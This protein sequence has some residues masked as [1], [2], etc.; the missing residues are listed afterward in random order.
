MILRRVIEHVKTQNW[1]AV[2]IDFA[3]VVVG[4]YMGIE[5]ANWNDARRDR[6]AEAVY[7]DRLGREIS[8]IVP[9]VEASHESVRNRLHRMVEVRDFFKTGEGAAALGGE[10]C[11]ALGTSHIF[12]ATIFYPPTIKEMIATG[13]IILIRDNVIRTAIL[14]LDQTNAESSQLRTDIQ[15][16]RLPLAR[17]Y[18]DLIT[19][20][21]S[22]W[23]D[24]TCDVES[25]RRN[26]SFLNDFIDNMQ[27]SE[28]YASR[29]TGRQSKV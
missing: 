29:V 10:H 22:S 7:L 17:A 3:I 15:I 24:S 20:G 6:V 26:R 5:V 1:F 28:A 27:R 8:E 25:M 2:G 11:A 14:S 23:A 9:E 13:R 21:L 18:P 19:L 4:V 16:D 12:A